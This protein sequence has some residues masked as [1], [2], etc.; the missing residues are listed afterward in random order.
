MACGGPI[1]KKVCV[2]GPAHR[3]GVA[4]TLAQTILDILSGL[5]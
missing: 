1:G 4:D 3:V 2:S 5:F